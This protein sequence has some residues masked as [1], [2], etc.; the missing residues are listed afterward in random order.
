MDANTNSSLRFAQG[1]DAD[2]EKPGRATLK[3][4]AAGISLIS[5]AVG[6]S[7]I[8]MLIILERGQAD[9]NGSSGGSSIALIGGI[10]AV[11]V[12]TVFLVT[13]CLYLW[14]SARR[15]VSFPVRC[16]TAQLTFSMAEPAITNGPIFLTGVTVCGER[17]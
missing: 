15:S 16:K 10:C 4:I 11:L 12:G 8:G 7:I 9:L 5:L 13:A 14:H 17:L 6:F 1:S 2:A 3:R